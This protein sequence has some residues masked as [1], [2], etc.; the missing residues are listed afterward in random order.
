MVIDHKKAIT[1]FSKIT[2]SANEEGL[3]PHY[4]VL[5]NQLPA[6]FWNTFSVKILEAAGEDLFDDAFGLL[7]NAGAECGYH[8]GHGII[9]SEEF[10]A[11]CKPMIDE[12]NAIE[13]TLKGAYTVFTAWGWGKIEI[14]ELIPDEKMI[15]RAY[16]YYESDIYG[17]GLYNKKKPFAAMLGGV[18]RAFMDLCYS[19]PY[20]N[21]F[22]KFKCKQTKGIELGDFYAEFVID[23]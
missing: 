11:V 7:E 21:G 3:I 14:I 16:D 1:D 12:N 5:I 9:T 10:E 13:D 2:V 19:D 6:N 15:I 20:P 17:Q 8:T 18:A 4:G 22:G 23:K